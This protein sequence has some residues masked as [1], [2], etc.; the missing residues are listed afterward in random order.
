MS[1]LLIT[2]I[3]KWNNDF[4]ESYFVFEPVKSV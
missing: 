1:S 3:L 4:E 2:L